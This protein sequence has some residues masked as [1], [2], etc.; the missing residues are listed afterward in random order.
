[1]YI[2][3]PDFEYLDFTYSSYGEPTITDAY[4]RVP[5]R[6]LWVLKG[7]PDHEQDTYYLTGSVVFEGIARSRR[8]I[9]E[10]T[11]LARQEFKAECIVEDGPFAEVN[12][13]EVYSCYIVG[14]FYVSNTWVDWDIIAARVRI[15]SDK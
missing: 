2:E 8:R 13:A 12:I 9:S 11:S 15:V 4:I 6:E 14:V 10:Y 5:V 1:M 7:F 3:H